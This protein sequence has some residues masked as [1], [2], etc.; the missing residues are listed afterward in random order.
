MQSRSKPLAKESKKLQKKTINGQ[1]NLGYSLGVLNWDFEFPKDESWNSEYRSFADR[2]GSSIEILW[3][4]G[5]LLMVN[6]EIM[7]IVVPWGW[8]TLREILRMGQKQIANLEAWPLAQIGSPLIHS[9]VDKSA[10]WQAHSC[11][12]RRCERYYESYNP[13]WDASSLLLQA[14]CHRNWEEKRVEKWND[15]LSAYGIYLEMRYLVK[16]PLQGEYLGLN[17]N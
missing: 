10:I 11:R 12:M 7:T 9:T 2:A 6:C 1:G 16:P 5:N 3:C 15:E 13:A 8:W 4:L 17:K 14:I